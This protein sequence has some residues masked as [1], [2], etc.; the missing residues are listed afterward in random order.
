MRLLAT[1]A[2]SLLT[3]NLQSNEPYLVV[4]AIIIMRVCL[5]HNVLIELLLLFFYKFLLSKLTKSLRDACFLLFARFP[6]F[7]GQDKYLHNLSCLYW[8][9]NNKSNYLFIYR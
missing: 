8:A 2:V 5:T 4:P 9:N 6:L 1:T 7:S 3:D